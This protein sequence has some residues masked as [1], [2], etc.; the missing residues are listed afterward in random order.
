MKAATAI[1]CGRTMKRFLNAGGYWVTRSPS[2]SLSPFAYSEDIWSTTTN[3][4]SE[5]GE[6]EKDDV[7]ASTAT[8]A[9]M[10][11]ASPTSSVSLLKTSSRSSLMDIEELD[12]VLTFTGRKP[13]TNADESFGRK[14]TMIA[15]HEDEVMKNESND[16]DDMDLLI[17]FVHHFDP[18]DSFVR[19]RIVDDYGG[20]DEDAISI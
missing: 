9:V 13:A 3:A 15:D 2:S 7:I 16:D 20:M 8:D 1:P 12:D 11:N 14:T 5:I 17:E 19:T 18:S 10:V 4:H 6:K